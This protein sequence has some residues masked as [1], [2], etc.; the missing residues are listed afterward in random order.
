[1]K[2]GVEKQSI[3]FFKHQ[4]PASCRYLSQVATQDTLRFRQCSYNNTRQK[5]GKE[6]SQTSCTNSPPP[7]CRHSGTSAQSSADVPLHKY[8][9]TLTT[10]SINCSAEP[11]LGHSH[12]HRSAMRGQLESLHNH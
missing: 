6:E 7:A 2:K 11:C 9:R 10:V 5:K 12:S 8:T 1:M 3:A 4:I